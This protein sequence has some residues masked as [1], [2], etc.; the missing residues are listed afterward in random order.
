MRLQ[1][2]REVAR[3]GNGG[4]SFHLLKPMYASCKKRREVRCWS[5][6]Q[7]GKPEDDRDQGQEDTRGAG[8]R[9]GGSLIS[10]YSYKQLVRTYQGDTG[11]HARSE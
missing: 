4:F 2:R 3:G 9:V 1:R 8:Y 7:E 5:S 10:M 11:S 6:R